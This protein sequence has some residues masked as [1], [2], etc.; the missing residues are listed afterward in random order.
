MKNLNIVKVFFIAVIA[1]GIFVSCNKQ[2]PNTPG[3]AAQEFSELLSDGK[4]DKAMGMIQG[5]D[6]ASDD[7]KEKFKMFMEEARE[8]LKNEKDGLK[9]VE[10]VEEEINEAGDE[11]KVT[12]KMTYGNEETEET[13][14][15]LVKED[16]EWKM[17]FDK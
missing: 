4:T 17:T 16:G 6:E 5:F 11:A 15:K 14:N 12:L 3:K 9:S 8:E 1:M 13:I 10:I 7:E 2:S